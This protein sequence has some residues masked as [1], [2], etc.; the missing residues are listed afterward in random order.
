V[1]IGNPPY[2]RQEL[3]SPIKPYLQA[4]Y[5]SNAHQQELLTGKMRLGDSDRIMLFSKI[6]PKNIPKKGCQRMTEKPFELVNYVEQTTQLLDWQIA[7]EYLPN[8]VENVAKI[9]AI[10]TLV[11]EFPLPNDIE[12][13]PIFEP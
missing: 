10:A 7:P 4:N 2:V 11:I 8:V 5:E 3:L 9:A 13:A 1:V 6:Y 12:P